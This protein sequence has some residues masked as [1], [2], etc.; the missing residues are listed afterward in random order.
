MNDFQISGNFQPFVE[1]GWMSFKVEARCIKLNPQANIW[2]KEEF[3]VTDTK[4]ISKYLSWIVL[5]IIID[6][7]NQSLATIGH[8]P[9]LLWFQPIDDPPNIQKSGAN[10]RG[11][12]LDQV[13]GTF[14][15]H[16]PI[17]LTLQGVQQQIHLPS[18]LGLPLPWLQ[19]R[20][21]SQA[22]CLKSMEKV[23]DRILSW[24]GFGIVLLDLE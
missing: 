23:Q 15:S 18:E 4:M 7:L 12:R 21:T 1:A 24:I 9:D 10:Y 5:T 13:N 19:E 2:V 17:Q 6:I 11:T 16:R 3:L 22:G 20:K 14:R 8:S